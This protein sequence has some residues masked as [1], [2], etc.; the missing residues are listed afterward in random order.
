MPLH[1]KIGAKPCVEG[2]RTLDGPM[3]LRTVEIQGGQCEKRPQEMGH[4]VPRG[5]RGEA[6][7]DQRQE[8]GGADE[9]GAVPMNGCS[10]RPPPLDC[11]SRLD[12]QWPAGQMPED[13]AKREGPPRLDAVP[14][15]GT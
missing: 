3:V 8:V 7:K 14:E 15:K 11:K 12:P 13:V 1:C 5:L 2:T 4:G 10:L 6:P 9:K